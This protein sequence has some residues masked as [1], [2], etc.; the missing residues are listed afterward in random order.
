[1]A[2]AAGAAQPIFQLMPLRLIADGNQQGLAD[3]RIRPLRSKNGAKVDLFIVEQTGAEETG[4]GQAQPVATVAEMM[5]QRA[6]KPERTDGIRTEL[7]DL[8]RTVVSAFLQ[9]NEVTFSADSR[10]DLIGADIGVGVPAAGSPD[11]HKFD[12]PHL[13]GHSPRQPGKLKNFIIIDPPHG[14]HIEF[15]RGKTKRKN[16]LYPPP[17]LIE[18]VDAGNFGNPLATQGIQA[19]IELAHPDLIQLPGV[20]F[21]KHAVGSDPDIVEILDPGQV[22][23]EPQYV[24]PHQWFAAGKADF[25]DPHVHRHPD[26]PQQLLVGQEFIVPQP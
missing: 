13:Q 7:E 4:R 23:D 2:V 5:T 19:D 22:A 17:D 11:G 12:K 24:P 9:R 25:G 6:D 1:M 10:H 8:R 20:A 26:N 21:Q 3:S 14:D 16:G 15:H 18:A